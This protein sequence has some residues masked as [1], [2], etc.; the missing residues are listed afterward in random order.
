MECGPG[1]VLSALNKRILPDI[2]TVSV[3]AVEQL[4]DFVGH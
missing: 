2:E 3:G 1:N 4:N